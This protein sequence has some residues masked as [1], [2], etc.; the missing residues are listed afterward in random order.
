[1]DGTARGI[2]LYK[3]PNQAFQYLEDKV[4]FKLDWST[5]S[6][7]EHHQESVAFTDGSNTNNDNSCLMEK[8]EALTIKI[9]SQFQ[10]LK[11][12]MH[13]MRKNYNNHGD[14]HTSKN[15]MNDDMPMC[16]R[17]EA[18][19]I[20]SEGYQNQNSHD[21]C[22]R[23]IRTVHDKLFDRDDGKTTGVLP[24][25]KSKTV[26]GNGYSQKNKNEAKTRQKPST[27]LERAWKTKAIGVRVPTGRYVVPT[28][29]VI[30]TDSVI[31]A[32]SG[33]VVPAAYDIS[34]GLKDLSR[35]ETYK[36]YQ[37]Q[38]EFSWRPY[39]IGGCNA[40]SSL[41]C[42]CNWDIWGVNTTQ[43]STNFS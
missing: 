9:D 14:N 32:T 34:P 3:T 25:K 10:S 7:N 18:N 35:A 11:E 6:K 20:Q 12:V 4:L 43:P 24:N 36:W 40:S 17:H 41:S 13:E 33:Y 30:A 29:R 26:N 21:S 27:G 15:H 1:M 38:T 42:H 19:Y 37:S 23:S 28:G 31:V 8:L 2:F 39:A 22:I 5:K 16:E